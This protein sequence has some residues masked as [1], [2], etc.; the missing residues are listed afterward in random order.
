MSREWTVRG[1]G[2]IFSTKRKAD[3][4]LKFHTTTYSLTPTQRLPQ[5][6][7]QMEP[8]ASKT[9]TTKSSVFTTGARERQKSLCPWCGKGF[10]SRRK[11]KSHIVQ[12]HRDEIF[13]HPFPPP[14]QPRVQPSQQARRQAQQHPRQ[15]SVQ[16]IKQPHRQQPPARQFRDQLSGQSH[17]QRQ[18]NPLQADE[19]HPQKKHHQAQEPPR[20]ASDPSSQEL[21]QQTGQGLSR[22]HPLPSY[23]PLPNSQTPP[24]GQLLP[25]GQPSQVQTPQTLTDLPCQYAAENS[26]EGSH[27]QGHYSSLPPSPSPDASGD[28]WSESDEWSDFLSPSD[29]EDDSDADDESDQESDQYSGDQSDEQQFDEVSPSRRGATSI[30]RTIAIRRNNTTITLKTGTLKRGT[31]TTCTLT[32]CTLT[33]VA[34]TV[35]TLT[36]GILTMVMIPEHLVVKND[37]VYVPPRACS[38]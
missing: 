12:S 21:R 26:H 18:R 23:R 29:G 15:P 5:L 27:A 25:S 13:E 37:N 30:R 22:G 36:A 19:Q 24:R 8:A 7:L 34:L 38:G 3:S 14:T 32:T 2:Y 9:S 4:E 31:L 35:N 11:I 17:P 28:E 20:Q 1:L 33:G 10:K 6:L 16:H